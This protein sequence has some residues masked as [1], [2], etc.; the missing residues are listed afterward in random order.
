[1]MHSTSSPSCSS[2]SDVPECPVCLQPYHPTSLVP[3]VLPC[4]HSICHICI[5][6][7]PPPLS[8][9]P[10]S[11][12]CPSCT[13]LVPFDRQLGPSSL[14]KN[15]DLLHF[16]NGE[17]GDNGGKG[18]KVV[19]GDEVSKRGFDVSVFL[20]LNWSRQ[21]LFSDVWKNYVL[22]EKLVV[23]EENGGGIGCGVV[24]C[25]TGS[26][27][28]CKEK[29]SVGVFK[30]KVESFGEEKSEW[31]RPSYVY[32]T[33]DAIEKLGD[34]AQNELRFL[35]E[36]T[37]II[38]RGI[39]KIYG[40]WMDLKEEQTSNL[41]LVSEKFV[42]R[43]DFSSKE[44]VNKESIFQ[45]GIICMELCEI[46]SNLHLQGISLGCFGFDCFS[47]DKF[48]HIILDLNR[49]LFLC[50]RLKEVSTK[51]DFTSFSET[52]VLLLLLLS[53]ELLN[54]LQKGPLTKDLGADE[55]I[56]YSSDVWCLACLVIIILIGDDKIISKLIQNS[57][58]NE[59]FV[60]FY[61]D[62]KKKIMGKLKDMF[63]STEFEALIEMI[64]S[65]LSYD[66]K[67]RPQAVDLFKYFQELIMKKWSADV[68]SYDSLKAKEGLSCCL[69]L[70]NFYSVDVDVRNERNL[71]L[72]GTEI[73]TSGTSDNLNGLLKETGPSGM[74]ENLNGLVKE[75][76]T[77]GTS[78][79][80]NGLLKETGTSGFRTRTLTGH[81]DCVSG[82][83]IGGDFLFSSSYDKTINVWSLKDLSHVQ[84]L[85]GHEHRVM[86][87]LVI[88]LPDESFCVSGDAGSG[89]FMWKIGTVPDC[90]EPYKSWYEQNDWR[91]SGVHSLAF[92]G[93]GYLYT[94]SG[95][96][97]VKAW[98]LLDQSLICTLTGHKSTVSCLAVQNGIL[99]SGSWDGTVRLWWITDHTNLCVLGGNSN[100]NE[101]SLAAPVLSLCV[102]DGF[103]AAACENGYM[104]IWRNEM[105]VRSDKVKT[106]AIYALHLYDNWIFTGG[107]DKTVNIQE[108]SSNETELE[109]KD[110][111][112]IKCQAI[113]TCLLYS[114]GKVFVGL[115]NKEIKVLVVFY[116]LDWYQLV[117]TRFFFLFWVLCFNLHFLAAFC[118][119]IIKKNIYLIIFVI[120]LLRKVLPDYF[121]YMYQV[122]QMES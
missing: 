84:T 6:L 63:I 15:L 14:P 87:I 21:R 59:D 58:S 18:G 66:S 109:M 64:E 57:N 39:C 42:Q 72:S 40:L 98:S 31:F 50:R 32:R 9:L 100:F 116:L 83:A 110:V 62:W 12:R 52:E 93:T 102:G 4:G 44:C 108:V 112:S 67:N 60:E 27:W 5:P 10:N 77:S 45:T 55:L 113:I 33:M 17:I 78:E 75:T 47:Y 80:L 86:A 69:L 41:Y 103:V 46:I 105:L 36:A 88:N 23:L 16:I 34:E 121:F 89:I 117:R 38:K 107:R 91:Y 2:D 94:G 1:M 22:P 71:N 48:G 51:G 56:G 111:A 13:Q 85:R 20:P 82:L 35:L 3:R 7:L 65:C 96:K 43:F 11:L 29:E 24:V 114:Q 79:N 74:S 30:M 53:P 92:S 28:F 76:G 68:A 119:F 49:V 95:D 70:A 26:P 118:Y 37:S 90:S 54:I 120:L 81:R 73:G 122:Y 101:G 106:G 97:S 25:S 99:Y 8:S 115:A 61:D 104:K 19:C